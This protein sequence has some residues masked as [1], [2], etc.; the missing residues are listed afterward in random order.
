M[1]HFPVNW[2]SISDWLL[3]LFLQRSAILPHLVM[4]IP[5]D[6]RT[7]GP[8]PFAVTHLLQGRRHILYLICGYSTLPALIHMEYFVHGNIFHQQDHHLSLR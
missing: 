6:C 8:Y 4:Y 7:T 3:I 2:S 1:S 5:P